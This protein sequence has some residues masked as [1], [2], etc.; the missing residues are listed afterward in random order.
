MVNP[1]LIHM[2]I[3]M[4]FIVASNDNDDSGLGIKPKSKARGYFFI[5]H[6]ETNGLTCS[7]EP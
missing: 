4:D 5:S 6:T 7:P 2:M 3:H 1:G